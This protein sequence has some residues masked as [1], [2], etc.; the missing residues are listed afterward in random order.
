MH[1]PRDRSHWPLASIS[2]LRSSDFPPEAYQEASGERLPLSIAVLPT[3]PR[4]PPQ[5]PWSRYGPGV[6][7]RHGLALLLGLLA[8]TRSRAQTPPAEL[9]WSTGEGDPSHAV[10]GLDDDDDDDDG[11]PDGQ[12]APREADD[13]RVR[14]E[15]RGVGAGPVAVAAQ[16]GLRVRVGQ[17]WASQ[18]TVTPVRGVATVELLGVEASAAADDASLELTAAGRTWRVGVTVVAVG[19]LRGDLGRL[20]AHRDAAMPSRH[21]TNDDTL[22]RSAAWGEASTD[23]HNLRA[24]VWDPGAAAAPVVRWE[25]V[26]TAAS[27]ATE[28][29]APRGAID[30]A[31]LARPTAEDPWRSGFVRLVGDDIDLRAPGVSSQVLRVALRDRV[32]VRYRRAGVA[33]EA[34]TDLRVG[35]PGREDGPL[36][37]RTLRARVWIP[38]DRPSLQGGRALVGGSDADAVELG[39]RQVAIADEVYA[40]CAITWGDPARA[41]VRVVDPPAPAMLAFGEGHGALASGGVLRVRVDGVALPELRTLPGWRPVDGAVAFAALLRSRGYTGHVTMNLRTTFG[42]GPSADVVVR[43][44]AGRLAVLSL[45]PG[46]PLSTD[47][48]QGA[49]LGVVDFSDGITEFSNQNSGTGTL[50][51]RALLKPL[52]DDAPATLTMVLVNRFTHGTRIGEAFVRN[53]GG[54]LG[55]AFLVDRAGAAAEREAW[56]QAHEAGHILLDQPWHPDNMGPDRPWLL[57]DADASLG[58]VAGPKRLSDE[59]CARIRARNDVSVHDGLLRRWDVGTASPDASRFASWPA[60]P[61]YPLGHA[62]AAT[63]SAAAVEPSDPG[64]PAASF[65]VRLGE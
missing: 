1:C 46:V 32:R 40:Q 37:A 28:P 63:A 9:R 36:A 11:V 5:R 24:E 13:D 14:I 52:L 16:G 45:V 30:G 51:E 56:T 2:V 3:L 42:A 8:T 49:A 53:D 12:Q 6:R 47:A 38:R 10:V 7:H 60:T 4:A 31:V 61:R 59:E 48:R 19:L 17:T 35:R 50:E 58:T 23:L 65:G 64:R 29:A 34:S 33:G 54:S 55:N 18:A 25:S 44:R 62:P 27:F 15:L 21:V 57:M 41:D 22:P 43:D 26:G 39:R 20:Y